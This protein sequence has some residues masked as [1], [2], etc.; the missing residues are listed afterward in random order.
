[1]SI[2]RVVPLGGLGEIG[3]NM[4][5][6]ECDDRIL[7]VDAGLMFAKPEMLGV[8]LVIPDISWIAERADRVEA[9][10]LTHGHEDHIGAVPFFL[11]RV[12]VPVYGT[13]M[14]LGLVRGKLREHRLLDGAT[15]RQV[16]PGDTINA[17]PFA[18]EF[19]HVAHSI[20]GATA[21]AVTT[22]AG[23]FLHSGDF[24]LDQTPVDGRPTDMARLGDYGQKGVT[25]F[26]SDSTNAELDGHTPSEH[27]VGEA[28]R[29]IFP[30]AEGRIIIT[31]FASNIYRQ[32]QALEVAATF[33]RKV[34]VVGRSMSNNIHLAQELGLLTVPPDTL[35][36]V[37]ELNRLPDQEA[38][39]LSTGAQG[40]PLS[41]LSR[42]ANREHPQ[43]QVRAGDT[44]IL[45][46]NP[47]PGNEELVNRTINNLYRHGAHVYY[48]TRNR[49]HV[50]GHA[51]AGDLKIVLNLVRPTFFVPIHGEDRHLAHHGRLAREVGLPDQN[52]MV[53]HDGAMI[54]VGPE[55]FER[56]GGVEAGYVFVDG[57]GIGD[58]GSMVLRDRRHL[59]QDGIFVMVVTVDRATGAVQNR[60]DV[61]T[62]GFVHE[63]TSDQLIEAAKDAVMAALAEQPQ[64]EVEASLLQNTVKEVLSKH[65]YAETKR[66][67]VVIP[68]V[69]EV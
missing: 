34:A 4:M 60:P 25:L 50:S 23:I 26:M 20:P 62:R 64:R 24:K 58:I 30:R 16:E 28:F 53:A 56:V 43:V 6:L 35:V 42:I 32:Q 1:M 17:G 29:D 11:R 21:L 55:R 54:E 15:L 52:V 9:L 41:A 3:L 27:M 33:G 5:A 22:P 45:S 69:V 39:V 47:I 12:N 7:V 13:R 65:L 68:V 63:G 61:V 44:V 14:T 49:V 31:T 19:I 40:E 46:A 18:V 36:S 37:G 8:D 67:P 48:S 38:V 59:S 57:L 10:V 66:R 51:S 2:L